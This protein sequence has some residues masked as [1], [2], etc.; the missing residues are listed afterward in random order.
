MRAK[1]TALIL[2]I[3][4]TLA[5]DVSAQKWELTAFGGYRWGGELNDGSYT[6]N[7]VNVRDLQFEDGPCWGFKAGYNI[8]PR[9]E[10]EIMYDRQHTSF[11]FVNESLGADTTLGDG[12]LDYVMGGVSINLL[13][14]E[15]KL[16]PYFTF[17]AGGAHLVPDDADSK[18]F[19]ALG[20]ALGASYF[21]TE[22]LGAMIENRG[23]STVVTG[24]ST[25][26]CSQDDPDNCIV[27]PRDT[28]MWQI[29]LSLGV[30]V[31]F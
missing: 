19:W 15:Y 18:W 9:F 10:A 4:A 7:T 22:N 17:Y 31:A 24:N 16:M 1:W 11:K 13:D 20:Y 8:N 28:W 27:L 3:L 12:K 5:T 6:D 21:F 29:G 2:V 26:F 23:T 30:V 14:P 25:L